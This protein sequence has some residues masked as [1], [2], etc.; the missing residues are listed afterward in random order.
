VVLYF[1]SSKCKWCEENWANVRA[2]SAAGQDRF[3]F[4]GVASETA[5]AEFVRAR[6]LEFEVV[7]GISPETLNAFG[8]GATPHTIVVSSQGRISREWVGA[9]EGRQQRSIESF[10]DAR[11]PGI[12]RPKNR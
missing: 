1:F 8:F 11:L 5:L 10:F 3:R 6:R 4:I 12:A 7:G 9:Y 2:L